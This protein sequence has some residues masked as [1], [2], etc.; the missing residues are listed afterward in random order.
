MHATFT[1]EGLSFLVSGFPN[2]THLTIEWDPYVSSL[3]NLYLDGMVKQLSALVHLS[4]LRIRRSFDWL[5]ATFLFRSMS[6]IKASSSPCPTVRHLSL[7]VLMEN[8]AW[9]HSLADERLYAFLAFAFPN[10]DSL[11]IF[12]FHSITSREE[13]SVEGARDLASMRVRPKVEQYR[14]TLW[15]KGQLRWLAIDEPLEEFGR[16]KEAYYAAL[17]PKGEVGKKVSEVVQQ[18]RMKLKE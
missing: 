8:N 1:Q 6:S 3:S 4:D 14:E 10:L 2:L 15:P 11:A 5:F 13:Y 12:L 17:D 9:L 16:H 18:D 7:Q